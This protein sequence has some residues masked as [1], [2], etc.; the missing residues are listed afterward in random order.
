MTMTELWTSLQPYVPVLLGLVW[1]VF[2]LL[3]V[4]WQKLWL[5]LAHGAWVPVVLLGVFSALIWSRL[6][7][8]SCNCLG[9]PLP[10]FWW[11]LGTVA[12]LIAVAL[13]SGWFQ[14][15]I[16]YAP[17]EINVEM[18]TGHNGHDHDH[19]HGHGHH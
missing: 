14:G 2:W 6:E 15:V 17:P 5:V 7:V 16:R 12:L 10:N 11:Q 1:I 18:P 19:G 4:N 9:F 8:R 13:L 3:C